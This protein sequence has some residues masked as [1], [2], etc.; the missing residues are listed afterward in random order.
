MRA[1]AGGHMAAGH[2]AAKFT[3]AGNDVPD[4]Y[5]I[6]EGTHRG[7]NDTIPLTGTSQFIAASTGHG[8]IDT[9]CA[10]G[11]AQFIAAD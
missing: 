8:E 1:R 9:T 7:G 11:T 5:R 6:A 3:S 2:T 10:F 4:R